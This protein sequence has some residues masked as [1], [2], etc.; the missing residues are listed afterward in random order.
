L[1]LRLCANA[2]EAFGGL[3]DAGILL[4]RQDREL[5]ER[6]DHQMH[7]AQVAEP[8]QIHHHVIG[9]RGQGVLVHGIE[10][11]ALARRAIVEFGLEVTG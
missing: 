10:A 3:Q 2:R 9:K 1:R 8:E 5:L 11:G 4:A 7:E 6:G